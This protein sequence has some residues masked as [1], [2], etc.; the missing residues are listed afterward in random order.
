MQGF[1]PQNETGELQ[2][3]LAH[4]APRLGY[5]LLSAH[6]D[7][8][9]GFINHGVSATTSLLLL[10]SFVSGETA[11][12][13]IDLFAVWHFEL[14]M[15]G[16]YQLYHLFLFHDIYQRMVVHTIDLMYTECGSSLNTYGI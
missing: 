2:I 11:N 4:C 13:F 7:S 9:A 12:H 8:C 5:A 3:Q 15:I 6:K 14:R 16:R 1:R 10:P